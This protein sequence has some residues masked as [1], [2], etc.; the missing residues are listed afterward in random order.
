MQR[1]IVI[2][3]LAVSLAAI[4]IAAYAVMARNDT[5]E[6]NSHESALRAVERMVAKLE[7]RVAELES[8]RSSALAESSRLAPAKRSP[9]PAQ[10]SSDE[11]AESVELERR[12]EEL[13]SR[14]SELE[15]VETIARR[16]RAGEKKLEIE[17]LR[18]ARLDVLD[19]SLDPTARL[20][21][22]D[23]LDKPT[24]RDDEV[25]AAMREMALDT[26]LESGVRRRAIESLWNVPT[27][28]VKQ[29]M[30]DLLA[31]DD[32]SEVRGA[33]MYALYWHA[34]DPHVVETVRS[35]S[36]YDRDPRIQQ[37]AADFIGK[38]EWAAS[39]GEAG[40]K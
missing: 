27:D 12:V 4:A 19:R 8:A 18:E 5:L 34:N 9:N 15:D 30:L 24:R 7:E 2:F 21:A 40:K 39:E 38:L 10:P 17:D 13:T 28:E 22:M 29:D 20:D 6:S 32:S 14:L 23:Q 35:I 36:R 1:G 3:G 16:A 33:S 25:V 11:S 37:N 31:T 26:N